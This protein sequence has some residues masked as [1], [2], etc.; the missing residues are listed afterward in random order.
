MATTDREDTS[1]LYFIVGGLVVLALVFA[2]IYTSN[3]TPNLAPDRIIERT[4]E[5][6]ILP[7]KTESTTTNYNFGT[8]ETPNNNTVTPAD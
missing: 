3:G 7:G 8:D 2:F 1:S 6:K 5:T 4:S